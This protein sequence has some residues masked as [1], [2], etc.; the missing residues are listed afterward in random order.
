MVP[1]H[2]GGKN[3]QEAWNNYI[4]SREKSREKEVGK[5]S[6]RRGTMFRGENLETKFCDDNR[7]MEKSRGVVVVGVRSRAMPA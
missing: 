4:Q 1:A 5:Q 2:L 3:Q 7:A 6:P